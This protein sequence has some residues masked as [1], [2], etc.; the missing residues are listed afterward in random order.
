MQATVHGRKDSDMTERLPL[1]TYLLFLEITFFPESGSESSL[2]LYSGLTFE[3]KNEKVTS[4][5]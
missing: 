1:L 2:V 3:V 5:L 4:V